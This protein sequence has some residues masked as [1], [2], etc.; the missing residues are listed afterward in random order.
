M[1]GGHFLSLCHLCYVSFIKFFPYS[2]GVDFVVVIVAVVVIVVFVVVGVCVFNINLFST[3]LRIKCSRMPIHSA[4]QCDQVDV[5]YAMLKS[6]HGEVK[7]LTFI[8]MW[9][10]YG[11]VM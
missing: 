6:G 9:A 1:E 8:N 11:I 5:Y 4:T 3:R 10:L 7:F 2:W